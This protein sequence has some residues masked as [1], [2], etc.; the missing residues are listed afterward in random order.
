MDKKIKLE[1][2]D[3]KINIS[4]ENTLLFTINEKKINASDIQSIFKNDTKNDTY[5]V[6]SNIDDVIDQNDKRYL[7]DV[8]SIF[9]KIVTQINNIVS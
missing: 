2:K 3:S 4:L 5:T 9:Q 1:F 8:V 6:Q 7:R